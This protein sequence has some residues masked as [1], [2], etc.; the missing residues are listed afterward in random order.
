MTF[1][2]KLLSLRE[3]AG[4]SQPGL[5]EASG[6]PVSTLRNYEQGRTGERINFAYVVKL[7]SALG[8]T[9]AAFA[10]CEDV[11]AEPEEEDTKSKGKRK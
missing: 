9:C 7:A 4:M 3:S 11:V 2:E 10:D 8:V 1:R 5:A 6:V